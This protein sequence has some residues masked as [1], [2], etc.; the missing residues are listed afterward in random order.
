[1]SIILNSTSVSTRHPGYDR[2]L[3]IWTKVRDCLEGEDTIKS[4]KEKYLPRPKGMSGEYADSYD[5]YIERAHFPLILSYA[6]SGA[7]GIVITKLPEF[8]VPKELEYIIE[9]STKD[10]R[11]L[12]QLF[13]DI[14]IEIFQT[15]RVPLLVDVVEELNQFRFVQYTAESFINWKTSIRKFE[16]SLILG[17]L[18]ESAAAT[19]DIFLHDTNTIYRVL[20]LDDDKY[21]SR[22]FDDNIEHTDKLTVPLFMG[23]SLDEIPLVIAGSINNSYN[24]QTVPLS[25]V[26]NCSVQI[27][28]KEADL[29][30]SEFLSC[31][32]TLV[33]TGASNEDELPNVVGSSVLI[34]VP[35]EQARV[36]YTKTDTAALTHVKSHI[37]SLYEEAIRHGVAI[38][39]AR[40]GVE[41]AEALRIRQSTQSASVYSIYLSA[42]NAIKQGLLLMCKWGGF[43]KSKIVIDAPT[44][45][46]Y[47]IPDSSVLKEII[48]GYGR[49][50]VPLR[51]VHKYLVSSG[52]LDQTIGYEEY[53]KMMDEDRIKTGDES[54]PKSN[55]RNDSVNN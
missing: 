47:N 23:E 12:Q 11:S 32:P 22:I 51:V 40:K 28:R 2:Y 17:V 39:D 33:I 31:N 54:S 43:D 34:V 38:L 46:T 25:S 14:V 35:H 41:A 24:M 27:Y 6:L 30:N 3:E 52:L 36:F 26:A 50:V 13:L 18:Q 45:L 49:T 15:G 16:Q 21:T 53:V 48:E 37:D 55:N 7:L 29:A 4:R 20:V 1:M 19:D 5:A 8:N 10:G 42:L 9:D 44:T